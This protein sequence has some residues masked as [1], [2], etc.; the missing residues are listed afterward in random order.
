MSLHDPSAGRGQR[1]SRST[2]RRGARG[3][4]TTRQRYHPRGPWPVPSRPVQATSRRP[5]AKR[6]Q[7]RARLPL[8]SR[9]R[10]TID[11]ELHNGH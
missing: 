6:Q 9:K 2:A 7:G 4:A 3:A 5:C 1:Q 10:P 8:A 11:A